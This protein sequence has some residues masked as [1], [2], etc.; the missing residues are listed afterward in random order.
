MI[1]CVSAHVLAASSNM[2]GLTVQQE[3]GTF[4]GP[5]NEAG[6]GFQN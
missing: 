5:A 6:V 1:K 3:A 4:P 2:I